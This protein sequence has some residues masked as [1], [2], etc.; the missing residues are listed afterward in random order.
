M[1]IVDSALL[2]KYFKPLS[3][4]D[5]YEYREDSRFTLHVNLGFTCPY[6]LIL[7]DNRIATTRTVEL[8]VGLIRFVNTL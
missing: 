5:Y 6:T 3:Q 7:N 8:A 2:R 1:N 4:P